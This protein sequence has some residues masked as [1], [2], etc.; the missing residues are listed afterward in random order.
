MLNLGDTH[1]SEAAV[2]F[3]RAIENDIRDGF[4]WL[5]AGDHASYAEWFKKKGDIIGAKEQLAKAIS[6][7][8]E[9]GADGWV[10]K[11]KQEIEQL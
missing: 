6:I 8:E 3:Q 5:V 7:F 10:K 4:M 1:L 2:W 9:C 11:Y